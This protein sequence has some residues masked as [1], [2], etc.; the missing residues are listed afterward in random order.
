MSMPAWLLWSLAV[1][2]FGCSMCI[3]NAVADLTGWRLAIGMFAA[4]SVGFS[5]FVQA[6]MALNAEGSP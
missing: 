5:A 2:E 1:Y 6:R 4:A 3:L